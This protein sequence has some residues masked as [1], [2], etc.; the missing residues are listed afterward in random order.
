MGRANIGQIPTCRG[1]NIGFNITFQ[2]VTNNSLIVPVHEGKGLVSYYNGEVS[3]R[4][5]VHAW[6]AC[7][8]ESLPGVRIS[9]SPQLLKL[10]SS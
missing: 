6:K 9:P 7:V 5:K 4:L 2:K 3:E 1:L 8:G 10:I